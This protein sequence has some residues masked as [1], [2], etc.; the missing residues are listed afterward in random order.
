MAA[1]SSNARFRPQA[2]TFFRQLKKHNAKPWFEA[3]RST[4]ESEVRGPLRALVE[5]MDVRFARFAPEI[6]GDPKRAIFRI[7]RDIRFSKDKS[8]YKTHA[9]CWFHHGGAGR[10]VGRE[11]EGGSAGFYFQLA[12]NDSFL[13]GGIWMPPRGS[14]AAIRDAIVEQPKSF[15]KIADD[16]ALKRRFGGLD[17][18]ARL[19][20]MPRGYDENHPAAEWLKYQSFTMGRALSD[21]Q[22]TGA[23]L[24]RILE[25]DFQRLL[26][27]V[28]WL[29]SAL[30]LDPSVRR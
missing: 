18:E 14:L 28:R 4:Y 22:V 27:L 5:E 11:G 20:R 30:G 26:P 21:A 29:N 12:P 6:V 25:E 16:P 23:R 17:A 9:A 13:G 1:L 7:H 8:P 15:L 10:T 2:L 3:N 19:K 24:V